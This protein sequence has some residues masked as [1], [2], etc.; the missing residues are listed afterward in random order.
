MQKTNY[1]IGTEPNQTDQ[2][3]QKPQ[4]QA[5]NTGVSGTTHGGRSSKETASREIAAI[6]S[7][8]KE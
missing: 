7:M 8:L 2:P 4:E 5:T 1:L 6:R 3:T